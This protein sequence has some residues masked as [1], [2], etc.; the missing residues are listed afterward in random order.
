MP[1]GGISRSPGIDRMQDL[2]TWVLLSRRCECSVGL[3]WWHT[4]GRDAVRD[5][6]RIGLP[7][8]PKWHV[9]ERKPARPSVVMKAVRRT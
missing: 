1:S 8:L 9:A 3:P 7:C 6:Q 4:H 5:G 2:H